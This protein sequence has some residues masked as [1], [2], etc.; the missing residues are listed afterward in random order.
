LREAAVTAPDHLR[1][2]DVVAHAEHLAMDALHV[3]RLAE[4]VDE[5]LPVAAR[6]DGH[7]RGAVELVEARPRG[8]LREHL[9]EPR[10]RFAVTVEIHEDER[11]RRLDLRFDE[12]EVLVAHTELLARRHL[13]QRAVEAVR[14]AV[15]GAAQLRET[16][17]GSLADRAPAVAAHVLERAQR[18][19]V[20]A[21]DQHRVRTDAVLV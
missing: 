5:R 4:A 1:A 21:Y 9:E 18:T 15:E 10:E 3:V 13:A 19:V 20:P 8:L 17:A 7:R 12:R 2:V 6:R 16:R 14:P 11:S